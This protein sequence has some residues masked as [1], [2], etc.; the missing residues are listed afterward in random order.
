MSEINGLKDRV[1]QLERELVDKDK[2]LKIYK[3]ELKKL[4]HQISLLID[5]IEGQLKVASQ[6]QKIL[7][8]TEF[9]RF[10]G[11][12][13]ST[14]YVAS[15]ISGGDYFD[16]YGT[17]A[18][19]H[20]GVILTASSGFGMSA[21]LLSV[22]IKLTTHI[23]SENP[24]SPSKSLTAIADDLKK[25]IQGNDS[26]SLFMG[27][28]DRRELTFTYSGSGDL[29]AFYCEFEGEVEILEIPGFPV[30]PSGSVHFTDKVI[31]LDPK[32]RL[33]LV[34][35]GIFRVQNNSGEEFGHQRVLQIVRDFADKGPHDLRNT[36]MFE[37]QRFGEGQDPTKDATVVVIDVKDRVLKLARN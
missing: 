26:A 33:V 20:F 32:D 3:S 15:A 4:N 18:K 24:L 30:V 16:I 34:S 7:V 14:R 31:E 8:P 29:L 27:S 11:F 2:D 25:S 13:F 21:L 17:Q 6:I 10:P 22:L 12:E 19:N 35:P 36:I 1:R 23:E 5:Q 28:F 9:P 37:S